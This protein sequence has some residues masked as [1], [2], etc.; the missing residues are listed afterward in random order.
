MTRV[1][2]VPRSFLSSHSA[3][4]GNFE[5]CLGLLLGTSRKDPFSRWLGDWEMR[6]K[7]YSYVLSC[8]FAWGSVTVAEP[9]AGICI[10][11]PMQGGCLQGGWSYKVAWQKLRLRLALPSE[12]REALLAARR[13]LKK[14]A[15]R[16]EGSTNRTSQGTLIWT[17]SVRS[18]F[19]GRRVARRLL[20]RLFDRHIGTDGQLY[21]QTARKSLMRFVER[22]GGAEV[23]NLRLP[24]GGPL[25]R[26]GRISSSNLK[27]SNL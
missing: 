12:K 16:N 2:K 19:S 4:R 6:R 17:L 20:R 15:G 7:Y 18:S 13:A 27:T 11:Q 25:L 21:F 5:T 10:A 1:D 9:R 26:I 24:K 14:H 8:G 23:A 22:M 3:V